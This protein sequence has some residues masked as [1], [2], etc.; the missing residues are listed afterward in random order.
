[1][2][3]EENK[4]LV[5]R[6]LDAF[7]NR[8]LDLWDEIIAADYVYH[9]AF[10]PPE[11]V[12]G[13]EEYKQ[14]MAGYFTAF[15]DV[16]ITIEDQIAEGDKVVTRVTFCGTHNGEMM[17]IAPTG[18]KVTI[19]VIF[20]VRFAEGKA[21]EEWENFDTHGMLRQIGAVPPIGQG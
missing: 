8:N 16:K 1:M 6:I 17:G 4:A 13:L 19:K 11:E 15:P 14:A 10:P 3:A 7:S 18:K 2:S 9:N 20:I 5:R 12:R 21:V